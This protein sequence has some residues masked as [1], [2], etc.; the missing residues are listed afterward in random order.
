MTSDQITHL[1]DAL[2]LLIVALSG[3]ITA[4]SHWR[5]QQMPT[6]TDQKKIADDLATTVQQNGVHALANHSHDADGRVQ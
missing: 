4:W 2:I 1:V 5:L 6:K 3:A